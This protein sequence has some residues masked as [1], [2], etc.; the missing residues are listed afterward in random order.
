MLSVS[1]FA[2]YPSEKAMPDTHSVVQ[3]MGRGVP[4]IACKAEHD[5]GRLRCEAM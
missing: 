2:N 4:V 5:L 3:E 1:L